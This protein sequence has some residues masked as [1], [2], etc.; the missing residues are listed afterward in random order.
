MSE[1]ASNTAGLSV[2]SIPHRPPFLFVDEIVEI[3]ETHIRTRKQADPQA[4]FFR[5]HYPGRPVMPGVLQFEC[6]FQAGALLIAHRLGAYGSDKGVPVIT[7]V[8]DGRFKR[9]V[10]PGDMLIVDVELEDELDGAYYLKA[11]TTVDGKLVSSV[12]F[13]AM[14]AEET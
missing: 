9:I 1:P 2:S 4:D 7:R 5:G 3:S 11:R 10:K 13:A 12:T 14:M 6:A 8:K